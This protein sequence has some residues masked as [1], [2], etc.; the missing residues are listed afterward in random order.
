MILFKP[1]W[2][3]LEEAYSRNTTAMHLSVNSLYYII[4]FQIADVPMLQIWISA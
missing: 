4:F 2:R 1:E 3:D